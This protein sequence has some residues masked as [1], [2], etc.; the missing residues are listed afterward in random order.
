MLLVIKDLS[1]SQRRVWKPVQ[2]GIQLSTTVALSLSTD[3]LSQVRGKGIVDPSCVM[4]RQSLRMITVAQYLAVPQSAAYDED[5]CTYLIDYLKSRSEVSSQS[6]QHTKGVDYENADY[7]A[8]SIT[9]NVT[10][11]CTETDLLTT[12]L[13]VD[14][15]PQPDFDNHTADLSMTVSG[16]YVDDSSSHFKSE[17]EVMQEEIVQTSCTTAP[18]TNNSSPEIAVIE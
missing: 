5:S 11:E 2:T 7:N 9:G 13:H 17:Q 16:D 6:T 10:E 12:V 8:V 4:F 1:F 14:D 18:A 15:C 3:V